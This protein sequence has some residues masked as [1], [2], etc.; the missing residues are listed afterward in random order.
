[1]LGWAEPEP[2]YVAE[3]TRVS[4]VVLCGAP[5][6][7]LFAV[8]PVS[9]SRLPYHRTTTTLNHSKHYIVFQ[10]NEGDTPKNAYSLREGNWL[11][12]NRSTVPI[13]W[14][15]DPLIA[16]YFPGL[17]EYYGAT[18]SPLD[19]FFGATGGLGYTY[20]WALPDRDAFFVQSGQLQAR[21]MPQPDAAV[22][23]WEGA[24]NRTL[25]TAF[26]QAANGSIAAF[27]QQPV[28][29]T[30][31]VNTWLTDGTPVFAADPSLWYPTQKGYCNASSPTPVLFACL[32]N[33]VEKVAAAHAPPFFVLI[34]GMLDYVDAAVAV[35]GAAVRLRR[36]GVGGGEE[37]E[38][39]WSAKDIGVHGRR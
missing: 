5:N 38:A 16:S 22:D 33:L 8:V 11:S 25:Y 28:D 3:L 20:P 6:L 27:S 32:Q 24:V 1:M 10:S 14:G 4:A 31:A 18:A 36:V 7:S 30:G 35:S 2:A 39:S 23:L 13:A 19:S 37:E 17:W 12:A 34:Y 29:G 15:V 26:A 21:Y 9:L